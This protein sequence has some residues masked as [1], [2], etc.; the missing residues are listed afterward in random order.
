[1]LTAWLKDC[2]MVEEKY[3]AARCAVGRGNRRRPRFAGDGPRTRSIADHFVKFA[4][5]PPILV[6]GEDKVSVKLKNDPAGGCADARARPM[7]PPCQYFTGLQR[8]NV[9]LR[10]SRQTP[11]ME[12]E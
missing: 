1:M 4:A 9:A 3:P 6:K 8:H 2:S 12:A 7:A 5:S 11:G 10:E